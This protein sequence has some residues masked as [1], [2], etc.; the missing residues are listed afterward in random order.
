MDTRILSFK[1]TVPH[2]QIIKEISNDLNYNQ[3]S[4]MEY[5]ISLH[6]SQGIDTIFEDNIIEQNQMLREKIQD[7]GKE[8]S[9][10]KAN[11]ER[12]KS[13]VKGLQPSNE[14]IKENMKKVK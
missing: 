9:K 1:T 14:D 8:I 6:Q 7:N 11:I 3:Q 2:C 4:V 12:L 13:R 5:L 10:M